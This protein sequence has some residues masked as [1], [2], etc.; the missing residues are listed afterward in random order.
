MT[1]TFRAAATYR[2]EKLGLSEV[3]RFGIS[4][5]GVIVWYFEFELLGFG[6]YKS[7]L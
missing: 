5:V 1:K 4:A 3:F 7:H 6:I 2:H